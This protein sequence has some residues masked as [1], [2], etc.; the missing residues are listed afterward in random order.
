MLRQESK[1][2]LIKEYN[3]SFNFQVVLVIIPLTDE[4][5]KP[6]MGI[7]HGYDKYNFFV[8]DLMDKI[9]KKMNVLVKTN[10]I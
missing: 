9:S 1:N 4:R 3:K 5:F 10:A 7:I 8:M 2:G 6:H